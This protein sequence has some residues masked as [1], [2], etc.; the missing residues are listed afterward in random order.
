MRSRKIRKMSTDPLVFVIALNY[1]SF[2]DTKQ[3]VDCLRQSD[4]TNYKL[5]VID[6]ASPDLSG[7]KLS[8]LLPPHEFL[9]LASNTG[10]AGGNNI[11]IELAL[12]KKAKYVLILNPD[13][14]IASNGIRE[15]V[16]VMEEHSDIGILSPIQ[17]KS[18]DG[19]VDEK[20]GESILKRHGYDIDALKQPNAVLKV[21][22]VLGAIMMVR[23][24]TFKMVGGFDPL[25]FAYGEEEDF[26]RRTLAR[27]WRIAVTSAAPA[28]HLRTKEKYVVADQIIFLRTKGNYLLALKNPNVNF[29]ILVFGVLGRALVDLIVMKKNRYPFSYYSVTRSHILRCM[30]WIVMHIPMIFLHRRKEFTEAAHIHLQQSTKK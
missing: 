16:K 9:S 13:V 25:F 3:C 19:L 27:G 11:G 20:F 5:L 24:H 29:L 7:E 22:R 14:R 26:C 4:Y 12:R 15:Y 6:N 8:R 10:Y 28:V 23:A 17:L 21:T 1:N 2:Q 30:W 18:F